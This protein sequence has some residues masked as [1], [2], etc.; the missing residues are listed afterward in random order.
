[1]RIL[2]R[3]LLKSFITTLLFS[4]VALYTIFLIVDMIENL[5]SFLDN[6][7]GII[8]IA[9]YYFYFFPEVLKLLVPVAMLLSTLFTVGRLSSLNEITA[10]KSGGISLYRFMAPLMLLS[11]LITGVHL[12]FN[13]WVVPKANI[14]K[15]DIEREYMNKGSS[16]GSIYDLY[17]RESPTANL[18]MKSYNSSQKKGVNIGLEY[19][20]AVNSPRLDKTI[21]ANSITWDSVANNWMLNEVI[22]RKFNS[23]N[24]ESV[25]RL[26]SMRIELTLTHEKIID[27]KRST[28]EMTFDGL[29]SYLSLLKNGGK[30]VDLEMTDYYGQYAFPIANIIVVLFGVPFASVKKKGGIAVQIGAALVISF[31]YL[32]FTKVSQAVVLGTGLN[33]IIAG[34]FANGLFFVVGIINLI[35]TRT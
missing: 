17:F 1:M 18:H 33:P 3:Y 35:K 22:I 25:S 2:D 6:G 4:F 11:I 34:W 30:N 28:D 15:N 14:A 24:I 21:E 10:I 26:D 5:E 20:T 8:K 13:G 9:E 16:V 32:I 19:F 12:Y 27:L 23:K 31:L 29:K 7:M